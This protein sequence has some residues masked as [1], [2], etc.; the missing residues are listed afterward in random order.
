M[1]DAVLSVRSIGAR[2]TGGVVAAGGR[3]AIHAGPGGTQL[4]SRRARPVTRKHGDTVTYN[5]G[6]ESR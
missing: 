1:I 2:G 3:A 6:V 5:R 4:R